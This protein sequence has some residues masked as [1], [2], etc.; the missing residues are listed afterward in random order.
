MGKEITLEELAASSKGT[1]RPQQT[2][3]QNKPKQ[4]EQPSK[5]KIMSAA[6]VEANLIKAGKMKENKEETVDAPLVEK[7]FE[8][9]VNKIQE[10][11]EYYANVVQPI[12]RKNMEE[13]I[14]EEEM[15]ALEGR[16]PDYEGDLSGKE[17]DGI[18]TDGRGQD[19][20]PTVEDDEFDLLDE[21]DNTVQQEVPER[22]FSNMNNNT[23]EEEPVEEVNNITE[24]VTEEQTPV[25]EVKPEE[26]KKVTPISNKQTV[27][28]EDNDNDEEKDLDSL[29]DDIDDSM[30]VVD[31]EDETPE[32]IRERFKKTF[33]N[34][35]ITSNPINFNEFKIRKNAVES[36]FVLSTITNNKSVKKSD[37][38]LFHSKKSVTFTECSG[39]ELDRLRKNISNSNAING[40]IATLRFVYDHID[41][42]NKPKFEVWTKLI[43]TEDIESLYF[44]IYKACYS[45]TNIIARQC[46]TGGEG[47]KNNCGK[48]SLIETNI[49]DMVKYGQDNDDPEKIK[50]EFNKIF[51]G[52]T[53]TESEAFESTLMQISDDIVISYCPATLY[54]TFIQ[55]STLK[56]EITQKYSDIL[57][58]MAYID[59]FY[60]IDRNSKELVPIQL[61]EWPKN[62]N[63][64]ILNRLKFYTELLKSLSSDQYNVLI[65]KLNNLIQ[66]PKIRYIYPETT[67]PECGAKIPEEP[68]DSV[69]NLLFSRAQLAQIKSL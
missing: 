11:K 63:K 28:V 69:L 15:A 59:G 43:R 62:F 3:Q 52:D 41:D 34:V 60:Q 65:G 64:T 12:V 9:M 47:Q 68:V 25:K 46:P 4:T 57:D 1:E 5:P 19:E 49:K 54:S 53:T 50:E 36:S 37:W 48:T 2:M 66:P 55:F 30:N 42:A 16:K 61:Q 17:Y 35:S 23:K 27:A 29:L 39:P 18:N 6:D 21:D 56:Q 44:G 22:H 7:A 10:K 67:C 14:L 45:N 58:S 20:I 8:S 24:P 51:N 13:I 38:V 32:E 26:H 33:S 40:V 31:T